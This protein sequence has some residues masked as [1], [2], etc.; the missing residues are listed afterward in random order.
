MKGVDNMLFS[1]FKGIE[2]IDKLNECVPYVEE[3]FSDKELLMSIKKM[4]WMQAAAPIYKKH[5]ES[6]EKIWEIL[7]IKPQNSV[8]I[9][10][11]TVEV[12]TGVQSDKDTLAFFIL[13]CPSMKSM[14]SH[15]ENIED[16]QSKDS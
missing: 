11:A 13:S 15:T 10:T 9:L 2:G 7:E 8:E 6:L 14:I 16:E 4:N 12:L 3:I 5:K 1:D